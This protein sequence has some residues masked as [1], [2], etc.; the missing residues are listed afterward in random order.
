MRTHRLVTQRGG[1]TCTRSYDDLLTKLGPSPPDFLFSFHHRV[2]PDL[3]HENSGMWRPAILCEVIFFPSLKLVY[4]SGNLELEP[5]SKST[6]LILPQTHVSRLQYS[7]NNYMASAF[8][9]SILG[10]H[11]QE[12]N[13]SL[14]LRGHD[15]YLIWEQ[16]QDRGLS[17]LEWISAH[18]SHPTRHSKDAALRE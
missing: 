15:H 10:N 12:T 6:C 9:L 3:N 2:S 16:D 5:N 18:C 8:L 11:L 17:P 14:E 4:L 13:I 1:V 7:W